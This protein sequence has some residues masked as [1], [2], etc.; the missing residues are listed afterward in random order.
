MKSKY[1]AAGLAAAML[2]YFASGAVSTKTTQWEYGQ[3]IVIG[4]KSV[5]PSYSWRTS[6]EY[7]AL[8]N[9]EMRIRAGATIDQF[10]SLDV[11][12]YLGKDGWELFILPNTEDV[13]GMKLQNH[14]FK[15][16][17]P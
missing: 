15:R 3:L 7:Y 10:S 16:C 14:Y 17:K 5:P 12:N 4:G 8:S 11:F 2:I 9:E 13:A 1:F 6:S